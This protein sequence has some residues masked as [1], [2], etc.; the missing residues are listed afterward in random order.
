MLPI[1]VVTS[2]FPNRSFPHRTVFVRNLVNAMRSHA[3]VEVIAPMPFA[4]PW[5]MVDRWR[6]LRAVPMREHI[7]GLI[8]LHPRY[9][10]I[11]GLD[12]LSGITYARSIVGLLRTRLREQGPFLV[13]AH[14]A[15]PDGVGV[16]N[17]AK[18]LGLP[19]VITAHG[20]DI[21]VYAGKPFLRPQIRRAFAG[22]RGVIAVSAELEQKILAIDA[23]MPLARIPCA[24]FDPAVFAQRDKAFCR[25]A[26]G[27]KPEVRLVTFV[28][29]LVA[30]KGVEVLLGAWASLQRENTELV[31]IGDGPE[32][33]RLMAQAG[34]LPGIRFAGVLPQDDVATWLGA[35]DL[36]VLPSL[37][38]GMPNVIVESLASGV[39]VVASRV[40]GIPELVVDGV[41][42]YLAEPG[43][44]ASLGNALNTALSRAWDG[45]ALRKS[46]AHLTWGALAA[47]NLAFLA[48]VST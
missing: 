32:R 5:T 41:N 38:E 43:D 18:A 14:C 4:P 13:H 9:V 16:A 27:I 44:V 21:N 11:S 37:N 47:E 30:V 39:P 35:S 22:A 48:R 23:G 36:L 29:N 46:T 19:Y 12:A 33:G 15:Y 20:S 17:V 2:F 26:L 24:G 42:G 45:I 28:G 25:Q 3:S 31:I 6:K 10:A 7:A 1:V 34:G 40:G 8:V